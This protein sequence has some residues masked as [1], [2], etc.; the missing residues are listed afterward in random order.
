DERSVLVLAP[1]SDDEVLGCGGLIAAAVRRGVRVDIVIAT[2][3]ALSDGDRT[4]RPAESAA[5]VSVLGADRTRVRFLD[6]PDGSLSNDVEGLADEIGAVLAASRPGLIVSTSS[7]DPHPDHRALGLAIARLAD[8]GRL[9]G[10]H[11]EYAI[12]QWESPK[13]AWRWLSAGVGRSPWAVL[14]VTRRVLVGPDRAAKRAALAAYRSQVEPGPDGRRVIDSQVTRRFLGRAEL[15][16][17]GPA[18]PPDG[19]TM[20]GWV[21][22]AE[23]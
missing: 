11:L 15:F 12:W 13:L 6:R 2:D 7:W 9:T 8:Q 16:R 21:I 4:V 17:P 23:S 20:P 10:D 19:P 22:P 14:R 5:A 1:H 3:G 18:T